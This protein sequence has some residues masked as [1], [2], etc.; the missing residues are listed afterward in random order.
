MED[1]YG[2]KKWLQGVLEKVS[3]PDLKFTVVSEF[4]IIF[5]QIEAEQKCSRTGELKKW[6]GRRWDVS[7]LATEADVVRTCFMAVMAWQEHETRENF[8]YCER[9]I[10]GPHLPIGELWKVAK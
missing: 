7:D 10:F 4:E 2:T 8:K 3:F 6:T 9:D 1:F 5:L